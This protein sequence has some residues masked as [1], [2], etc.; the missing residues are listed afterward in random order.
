MFKIDNATFFVPYDTLDI[1][2][3]YLM[4]MENWGINPLLAKQK[5]S[6][7]N[8]VTLEFWTQFG[9]NYIRDLTLPVIIEV[10]KAIIKNVELKSNSPNKD[11]LVCSYFNNYVLAF[12]SEG[13]EFIK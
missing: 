5:T 11:A 3:S 10:P 1:D 4:K 2:S 13:C 8:L 9:K 7:S 6:V 12:R